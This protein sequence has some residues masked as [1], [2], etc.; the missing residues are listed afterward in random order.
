MDEEDSLIR[1]PRILLLIAGIIV[2]IILIYPHPT[3]GGIS[4]SLNYGLELE[5]G[6][7][8]QLELQGAIVEIDSNPA[9]IIE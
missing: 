7:W 8:L 5:G 2:S 3:D 1:D 9:T 4:T 6:S